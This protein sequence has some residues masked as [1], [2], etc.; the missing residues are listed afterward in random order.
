MKSE[1]LAV[2]GSDLRIIHIDADIVPRAISSKKT[3]LPMEKHEEKR[4]KRG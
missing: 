4:A 2:H 3:Q 1:A